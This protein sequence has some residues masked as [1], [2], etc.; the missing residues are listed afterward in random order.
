CTQKITVNDKT[1][2]YI[3]CPYD[4][5]VECDS[6]VPKPDITKVTASDNCGKV[7]VS[8]VKDSSSYGSCPKYIYRT[9]KAKDDCGNTSYCTQKI[10]VNDTKPPVI[11]CAKDKEIKC[12]DSVQFDLP[13]AT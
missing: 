11:T 12:T 6:D 5:T 10:T 4:I 9:Y 8:F 2:P 13:T 7:Y 1:P 3:K